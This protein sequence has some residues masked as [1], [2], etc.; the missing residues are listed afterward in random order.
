MGPGQTVPACAKEVLLLRTAGEPHHPILP[1]P[2]TVQEL[3]GH[4][5]DTRL[6][7]RPSR[8]NE[9][10]SEWDS[11]AGCL[12][13][14]PPT[15]PMTEAGHAGTSHRG[16]V[17]G[18]GGRS[19][20][21]LQ[22]NCRASE[23]TWTLTFQELINKGF[24]VDVLLI[25]DPP[26]LVAMGRTGLPGFR[27]VVA[28]DTDSSNPQAV[29]LIRDSIRFRSVRPFGPRIAAAELVGPLGSTVVISAYIRHTTGEGLDDL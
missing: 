13:F 27:L 11:A 28:P 4:A 23:T 20:S 18:G 17:R 2:T 8:T 10:R 5:R 7:T 24:N 29:I 6:L 16:G 26:L 15:R 1:Q 25:Q 9:A 22:L 3:R 19:L 21:F 12:C 14:A